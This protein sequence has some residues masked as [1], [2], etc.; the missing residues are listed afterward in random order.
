MSFDY[1]LGDFVALGELTWKIYK[2]CQNAP[3]GFKNISQEVLSSHVV[4]KE[5]EKT[6]LDVSMS[7]A[8][9]IRAQH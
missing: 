8:V 1:S 9:T 6:Y 5:V 7:A 2:A 3:E 4:I